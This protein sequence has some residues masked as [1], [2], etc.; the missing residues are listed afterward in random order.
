MSEQ[1]PEPPSPCTGIC[2]LNPS[3][4]LC[5]GCFRSAAEIER[6]WDLSPKEKRQLL[7]ELEGRRHQAYSALWD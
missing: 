6:W 5:D 7:D 3:T 1:A 4:E 2:Q